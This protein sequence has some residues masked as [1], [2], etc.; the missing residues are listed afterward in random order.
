MIGLLSVPF[1]VQKMAAVQPE[2]SHNMLGHPFLV[3]HLKM[4]VTVSKDT[5]CTCTNFRGIFPINQPWV[6]AIW[7]THFLRF[8]TASG[9]LNMDDNAYRH[10]VPLPRDQESFDEFEPTT[11]N[12]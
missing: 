2:H 9:F 3:A 8:P 4:V 6:A 1:V 7:P 10:S 5:P 11:S 12:T